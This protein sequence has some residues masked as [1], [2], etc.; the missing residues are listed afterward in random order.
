MVYSFYLK[1]SVTHRSH[2]SYN[3][4][5]KLEHIAELTLNHVYAMDLDSSRL[6]D[7]RIFASIKVYRNERSREFDRAERVQALSGG[8]RQKVGSL[9]DIRFG[10]KPNDDNDEADFFLSFPADSSS[11]LI[12]FIQF[13]NLLIQWALLFMYPTFS[14]DK[15]T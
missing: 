9:R 2:R 14:G 6:L 11:V 13:A 15:I 8:V 10:R 5:F 7:A 4:E 3:N 12:C 1:N